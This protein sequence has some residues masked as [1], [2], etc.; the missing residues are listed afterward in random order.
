MNLGDLTQAAE[1]LFRQLNVQRIAGVSH[2]E[3]RIS[4]F[5]MAQTSSRGHVA[6]KNES[7]VTTNRHKAVLVE[8]AESNVEHPVHQIHIGQDESER[9]SDPQASAIQRAQQRLHRVRLQPSRPQVAY[10]LGQT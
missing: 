2:K 7:E 5:R 1:D 9:L 10:G 8:L 6:F 4:S 3:G